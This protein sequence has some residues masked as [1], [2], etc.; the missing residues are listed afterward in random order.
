M[1]WVSASDIAAYE[2]CARAYWLERVHQVARDAKA[3]GRLDSGH[4]RH[5]AH[6]RRVAAQRWLVRVAIALIVVAMALVLRGA[7]L[8]DS[9]TTHGPTAAGA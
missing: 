6:G 5:R 4:A 3:D 2:Y 7:L 8:R 1:D 9:C